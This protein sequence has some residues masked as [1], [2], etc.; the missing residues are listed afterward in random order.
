MKPLTGAA[1]LGLVPVPP[2][3]PALSVDPG[4]WT[5]AGND[6]APPWQLFPTDTDWRQPGPRTVMRLLRRR[7]L[8]DNW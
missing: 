4:E 8:A 2:M 5:A 6:S 7:L 1:V 3:L